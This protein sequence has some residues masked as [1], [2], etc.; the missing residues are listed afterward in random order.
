M[1]GGRVLFVQST[2]EIGGAETVLL[3]LL[4]D[5]RVR[6]RAAVAVLGFGRGD[7][8]ERLQRMSVEVYVVPATRMR[9][10]LS[11]YRTTVAIAA[12]IRQGGF[13]IVVGNGAHPQVFGSIASHMTGAKSVYFV[14]MIHDVRLFGN[15]AVDIAAIRGPVDLF[16]C[17]SQTS[18]GAVLALRPTKPARVVYPGTAEP[19]FS[20]EQRDSARIHMTDGMEDAVV[21]S[22]FGRLQRWK[23]QDIFLRAAKR[24]SEAVPKARF[25]IVGGST[26]DLEIEFAAELR[27]LAGSLG[28]G[29]KTSFLGYQREVSPYYAASDVVCHTS[30]VPEPFGMVIIEAMAHGKP[31]I[32]VA[33]GGPAEIVESGRNGLLVNLESSD[34]LADCMIGLASDV[35]MRCRLGDAARADYTERFTVRRMAADFLHALP[36]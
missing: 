13:G 27:G 3:N 35:A 12:L 4:S 28:I 17:N 30:R 24:V 32:A 11:L 33:A 29:T 6:A 23:G 34:E 7:L 31:I 10:P 36:D 5:D 21:F 25:A 15:G 16:M 19:S 14:H 22:L 8:V 20:S 1:T 9:H 18:E 2:T 26:F